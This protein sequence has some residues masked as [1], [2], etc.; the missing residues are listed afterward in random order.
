MSSRHDHGSSIDDVLPSSLMF[1]IFSRLTVK[2][3]M[4][5]KC[6]CKNWRDLVSDPYFAHL[7]LSRSREALII[8]E[9]AYQDLNKNRPGSLEWVEWADYLPY[10]HKS[11]N[12]NLCASLDGTSI[13]RVGS[14]NGLVSC[15]RPDDLVC[16]FNPVLEEY[17]TL[18]RLISDLRPRF[19]GFGVSA[20]GEYKMIRICSHRVSVDPLEHEV[21][22]NVYTLGTFHWRALGR[23]AYQLTGYVELDQYPHAPMSGVF[24]NS[25]VYFLLGKDI[26][27]VDLNMETFELFRSPPGAGPREGNEGESK[28]M[29]GV[30]KGRLSRVSW[31]FSQ[32]EV[33]V[34]KE[35]SWYKEIAIKDAI[36]RFKLGPQGVRPLCLVDGL[37][38]ASIFMLYDHSTSRLMAYCLNTNT[39]LYLE[40]R[41]CFHSLITYRP[42]FIKLDN[43]GSWKGAHKVYDN[44]V[45]KKIYLLTLLF[46]LLYV[47]N[48]TSQVLVYMGQNSYGSSTATSLL[49]SCCRCR[50]IMYK[51]V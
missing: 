43:F 24:V 38:G 39:V 6:V 46:F 22:V 13:I 7:H 5:C 2:S 29:L 26:Y 48:I 4:L 31:C 36:V 3:I 47:S 45:R 30:L 8:H 51:C 18:S 23:T 19:Y 16:V 27:D 37:N 42:S 44:R 35:G 34:M 21:K 49:R 1:D 9:I 14:V 50:I 32:L 28:H 17:I 11:L 10:R 12:L 25:H 15:Q 41:G 40:L 33:W 20:A